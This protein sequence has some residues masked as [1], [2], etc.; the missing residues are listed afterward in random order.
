MSIDNIIIPYYIYHYDNITTSEYLGLITYEKNLSPVLYKGWKLYGIFYAFNPSLKPIPQGTV[1]FNIKIKNYFPY[2]IENCKFIYDI[3]SIDNNDIYST[4]F[5]TYIRP[6][7]NTTPLYFHKI[8]NSVYPSFD[9]NPPDKGDWK[10][11]G[12]DPVYVL[13]SN[14]DSFTCI[15]GRCLQNPM[16]K[17]YFNPNKNLKDTLL[18]K[19]CLSKCNNSVGILDIVKKMSSKENLKST[20]NNIIYYIFFLVLLI[21]I[22]IILIIKS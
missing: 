22:F 7:P 5:I 11:E 1:L 14:K 13:T 6:F 18:I 3:F 20:K 15:N 10:L 21:L 17:N 8:N 2:D 16:P 19:D 9:K 4:N 12:I